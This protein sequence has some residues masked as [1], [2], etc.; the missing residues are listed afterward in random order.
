M[1]KTKELLMKEVSP[2]KETNTQKFAVFQNRIFKQ[3][4]YIDALQN[5]LDKSK[6]NASSKNTSDL[7]KARLWVDVFE[8]EQKLMAQKSIL[9]QHIR[10]LHELKKA[11]DEQDL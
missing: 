10:Y 9:A 6:E 3:Q 7:E 2:N 5:L 4:G 8:V 11:E 1:A